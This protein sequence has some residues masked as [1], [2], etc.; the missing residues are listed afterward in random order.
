MA[1]I[2]KSTANAVRAMKPFVRSEIMDSPKLPAQRRVFDIS[3]LGC[4]PRY[5]PG[6][7]MTDREERPLGLDQGYSI[8]GTPDTS[9]VTQAAVEWQR[10]CQDPMPVC[11]VPPASWLA[12]ELVRAIST[13]QPQD[14]CIGES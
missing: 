6:Q 9:S 5:S 14:F 4:R 12:Q 7:K 13:V 2:T 1:A 10:M 8:R 3:S 11:V